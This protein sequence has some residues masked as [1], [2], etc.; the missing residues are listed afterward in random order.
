MSKIFYEQAD[1][2][3]AIGN[4]TLD[5]P[6]GQVS[7]RHV[8]F[9]Y[10]SRPALRGLTLDIPAGKRVAIVGPSG[11]GKSTIVRLLFRLY[12]PK[13]GSVCIDEVSIFDIKKDQYYDIIA[14]VPQESM[15]FN[16]TI[17]Q[18]IRFGK[19][20]ASQ[21]EIEDAVRLAN[22]TD[23][24]KRLPDGLNTVVGERG[25][26]L[27]GGE[28]QRVAIARAVVKQPKILVFDE[29]TSNLDAE[30]EQEI[31]GA[32]RKASAGRTT[33]SIAH[34]LSTIIDSDIIFVIDKGKLVES[35]TH[36]ELLE[37]N[38]LYARLWATYQRIH[39]TI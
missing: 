5:K 21:K 26:K 11:A 23:L 12:R 31:I 32:I 35:G 22:L 30:A 20:E 13:Q 24:I 3:E 7:F 14:L 39:Q 18:N 1:S 10:K 27:S 2:I 15:L 17:E 25:V 19:P 38:G 33:I 28:K 6:R 34:R 29:A 36:K 16:D 8:E 37:S 9:D 4:Y